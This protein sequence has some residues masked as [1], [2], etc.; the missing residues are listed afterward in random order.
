[1]KICAF[2]IG[3]EESSPGALNRVSG[4]AESSF[5][6]KLSIDIEKKMSKIMKF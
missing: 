2:V 3:H 4:V 5:K 1:M 6:E